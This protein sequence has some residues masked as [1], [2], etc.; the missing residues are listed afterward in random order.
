MGTVGIGQ[1]K[2]GGGSVSGT[3][4]G[5]TPFGDTSPLDTAARFGKA[6]SAGSWSWD[7]STAALALVRLDSREYRLT[8]MM[9]SHS[10]RVHPAA[11]FGRYPERTANRDLG[12]Y[13]TNSDSV[14][15]DVLIAVAEILGTTAKV[16]QLRVDHP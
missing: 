6:P 10:S 2:V 5:Q 8:A 13:S 1:V 15:S 9:A 4:V 16:Q 7:G 12:S 3:G 11:S 14:A